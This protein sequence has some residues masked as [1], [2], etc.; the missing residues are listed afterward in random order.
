LRD[1]IF[2]DQWCIESLEYVHHL[3]FRVM[4]FILTI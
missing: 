3:L 2:Y 1:L 4:L